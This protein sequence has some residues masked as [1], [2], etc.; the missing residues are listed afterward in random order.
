MVESLPQKL[1]GCRA[2]VHEGIGDD[3]GRVTYR[4]SDSVFG[5]F[6]NEQIAFVVTDEKLQV[7]LYAQFTAQNSHKSFQTF[8]HQLVR[9]TL[10]N[11]RYKISR[12][13][14]KESPRLTKTGS[15]F[16]SLTSSDFSPSTATTFSK[17]IC[18]YYVYKWRYKTRLTRW[19]ASSRF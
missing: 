14:Q 18:L 13:K 11:R 4:H 17:K 8:L 6:E 12:K 1:I 10:H 19:G 16:T 5:L 2:T 3:G 9:F 15:T 7:K